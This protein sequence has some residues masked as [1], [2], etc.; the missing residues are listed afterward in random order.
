MPEL[1]NYQLHNQVSGGDEGER[2]GSFHTRHGTYMPR[3]MKGVSFRE[4]CGCQS[5]ILD[6]EPGNYGT[7]SV[8]IISAGG[9]GKKGTELGYL[10]LLT[11]YRVSNL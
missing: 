1:I 9:K 11:R 5:D 6:F 8:G 4:V 10:R 7:Y 3:R 2:G